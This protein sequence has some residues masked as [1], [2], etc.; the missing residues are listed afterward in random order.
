MNPT[1]P[2]NLTNPTNPSWHFPLNRVEDAIDELHRFFPAERLGQLQRFVDDNVT[3]RGAVEKLADG[4]PQ[5]DAVE[6]GHP[7][8]TPVLCRFDDDR[9]DRPEV[10]DRQTDKLLGERADALWRPLGSRQVRGPER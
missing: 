10:G 8:Q 3:R 9:I 1:T 2:M 5:D 7:R 4:E 6:R